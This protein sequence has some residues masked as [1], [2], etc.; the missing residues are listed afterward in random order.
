MGQVNNFER[1]LLES[2]I[3]FIKFYF[4]ITKEEQA[5]RFNEIKSNQLKR[6]KI[7]PVDMRAQ[8]IWD[9][10]TKYKEKMFDHTNTKN[11]PWVVI[12]ANK[13]TSARVQAL[14]YIVDHISYESS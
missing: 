2:D 6:W 1:M 11:A 4:S 5:T 7:T 3:F 10:Y 8:E 12:E 9:E 13:K 14:Q